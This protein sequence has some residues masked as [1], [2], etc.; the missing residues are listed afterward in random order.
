MAESKK[1]AIININDKLKGIVKE[2]R[3]LS[4]YK[5][6]LIIPNKE[7]WLKNTA[8]HPCNLD[9][10]NIIFS[11][12]KDSKMLQNIK[13]FESVVVLRDPDIACDAETA[14]VTV[15]IEEADKNIHTVAEVYGSINK[16]HIETLN[17][18]EIVCVGEITEKMIAQ[19]A[20]TSKIDKLF[21]FLLD[22]DK[23]T[24]EIFIRKL[25]VDFWGENK[26]F[27]DVLK[28]FLELNIKIIPIGYI[29]KY[30]K[31][32]RIIREYKLNPILKE[33]KEKV[34]SEENEIVFLGIRSNF[35]L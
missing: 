12:P 17:I 16:Q 21:K 31:S 7:T 3:K 27:Q 34:L 8:W 10:I 22:T 5:I 20:I 32:N 13:D 33:D 9:G 4:D 25:P 24:A 14:L 2:I 6:T 18:D 28:Y 26:T 19:G 30:K 11:N 35:N 1:I 23:D 29:N 15:A